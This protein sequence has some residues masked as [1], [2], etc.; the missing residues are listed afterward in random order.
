MSDADMGYDWL[1]TTAYKHT[2]CISIC[3][4]AVTPVAFTS[5]HSGHSSTLWNWSAQRVSPVLVILREIIKYA[6]CFVLFY[7]SLF[8]LIYLFQ[9]NAT[10]SLKLPKNVVLYSQLSSLR[11]IWMLHT[12]LW[13]TMYWSSASHETA[14]R[15]LWHVCG[16]IILKWDILYD[17]KVMPTHKVHFYLGN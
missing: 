7:F 3:S 10:Q 13:K 15:F 11:I 14:R 12:K 5:P 16:C 17:I 8:E 9:P 4:H 6:T 1:L 2:T